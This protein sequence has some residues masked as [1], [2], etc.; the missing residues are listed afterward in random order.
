M[1]FKLQP[2]S[3][4]EAA[5]IAVGTLLCAAVMV[6]L[7]GALHVAG[8]YPFTYTVPLAAAVGSAVTIL[9]F[10]LLCI[11]MQ[12]AMAVR[13]D[14]ARV[15]LIIQFSYNLRLIMQAGWCIA[16]YVLPCFQVVAGMLPLLFPRLVIVF[17]QKSG[18]YPGGTPLPQAEETPP[19]SDET[20]GEVK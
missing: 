16:A 4:Q 6:A 17:L 7:F 13:E 5:R 9:N 1:S 11:T 19:S 15:R 14:A 12:N 10:Y 3:R 2:D 20:E 18:Q 8:L